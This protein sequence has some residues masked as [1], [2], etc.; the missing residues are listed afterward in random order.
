MGVTSFGV[1]VVNV[2]A[3][4]QSR[5]MRMTQFFANEEWCCCSGVS[6][7]DVT[8][9]SDGEWLAAGLRNLAKLG[10]RFVILGDEIIF[11]VEEWE[12]LLVY[13]T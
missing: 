5:F 13:C 8:S 4:F 9:A 3:Y 12:Y 10:I 1:W 6:P 7:A 11:A 2:G